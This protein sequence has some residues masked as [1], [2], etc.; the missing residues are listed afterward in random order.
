MHIPYVD[1]FLKKY[2]GYG[3]D[4]PGKYSDCKVYCARLPPI[5]GG[6]YLCTISY[7]D[8]FGI[9]ASTISHIVQIPEFTYD[10]L[11]IAFALPC[12]KFRISF[13]STTVI[14]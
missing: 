3:K 11:M 9:L 8:R 14:A 1:D 10:P 13:P 12:S 2:L 4:V 6:I 7:Y 5:L